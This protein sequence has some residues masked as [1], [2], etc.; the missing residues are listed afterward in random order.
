MN[1]LL[2]KWLEE[3]KITQSGY[4]NLTGEYPEC[5][6]QPAEKGGL[7]ISV[8]IS[9]YRRSAYLI[10]L[11]NSLRNQQYSNYE[12]IIVDDASND[13]TAETL[14]QYIKENP[15]LNMIFSVNETNAGASESRKRAYSKATGDIIIFVD[16]DDYYIEPAYFSVL[17]ELYAS[18]SDCTMTIAETIQNTMQEDGYEYCSLNTPKI[19]SSRAYLN[20]FGEQYKQPYIFAVS[21]RHSTLKSIRFEEL[22]CFNH[23][24]LIL[25]GLLGKGNIYTISQAV[26]MRQLH[27]GNM[28]CHTTAEFIIDNMDA[29]EDIYQRAKDA[30]MLDRPEEWHRRH[31]TGTAGYHFANKRRITAEDKLI[32]NWMKKHFKL[33]D[34]YRFAAGIMKSRIRRML[35]SAASHIKR[36]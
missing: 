1:Q 6:S 34:Y 17:N 21:F 8:L 29:K 33:T 2:E 20:G 30:G 18:H 27:A 13:D 19:L 9:T 35:S 11:L 7:K 22:L 31:L 28:S 26:G 16:D 10:R 15:G 24:S 3:G 32:F 25:F 4:L 23:I 12:I 5:S 14:K 36:T